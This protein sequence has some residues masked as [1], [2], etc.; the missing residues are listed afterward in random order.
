MNSHI[1]DVLVVWKRAKR[2]DKLRTARE[3]LVCCHFA[4]ARE[5]LIF[6]DWLPA[7]V[8]EL[9]YFD[10]Y[11]DYRDPELALAV[12]RALVNISSSDESHF[13]FLN[14]SNTAVLMRMFA[15]P[16]EGLRRGEELVPDGLD[17]VL[18]MINCEFVCLSGCVVFCVSS[19]GSVRCLQ[20]L[21][22]PSLSYSCC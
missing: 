17:W 18:H 4:R 11:G 2:N 16:W 8:R 21:L 1:R 14:R 7:V 9:S 10:Q 19:Q 3:L 22:P 20:R 12:A 15:M 13:H 5:D 6:Q